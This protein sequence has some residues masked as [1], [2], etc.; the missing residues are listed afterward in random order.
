MFAKTE[1]EMVS[2]LNNESPLTIVKVEGDVI[3][4]YADDG[5]WMEEWTRVDGKWY[6][7]DKYYDDPDGE[8]V[9]DEEF[10]S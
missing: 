9:S 8:E 7:T 10:F 5:W 3:T 6:M 4:L 2:Y 1:A